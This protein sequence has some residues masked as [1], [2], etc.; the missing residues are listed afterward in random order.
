MSVRFTRWPLFLRQMIC[1]FPLFFFNAADVID[2]EKDDCVAGVFV[3]QQE[4]IKGHLSHKIDPTQ[5]GSK[6]EFNFPADIT[7]TLK[8]ITPDSAFIFP[9]G[10]IY[11]YRDCEKIFRFFRGGK[12]LNVQE[13]F[14]QIE[15]AEQGFVVYSSEFV[16]GNEIFYS[17]GLTSPIH[18]LTL[19]NLKRDFGKYPEFIS[20]ARKLK[21]GAEGIPVRDPDGF[22]IMKNYREIVG[23]SSVK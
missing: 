23:D 9:A 21:R 17:M 1:V 11:G 4:F 3:T 18:R 10:S 6:L 20:R 12:E 5:K 19:R 7:L 22:R 2:N 13:D 15:E 16:S 14:Y 8:I